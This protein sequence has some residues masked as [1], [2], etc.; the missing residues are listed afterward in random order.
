MVSEKDEGSTAQ[1]VKAIMELKFKVSGSFQAGD[2]GILQHQF[3]IKRRPLM[4][5]SKRAILSFSLAGRHE[6]K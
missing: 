6:L 1:D 5:N 3:N 2:D 4:F